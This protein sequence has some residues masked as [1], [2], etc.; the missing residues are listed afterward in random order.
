MVVWWY[1]GVCGLASLQPLHYT[2]PLYGDILLSSW[3]QTLG[4][5]W[6]LGHLQV[7]YMCSFD[8]PAVILN[9]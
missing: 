1:D 8:Y 5:D 3:P 2:E 7:Q 4:R 9:I 6:Q